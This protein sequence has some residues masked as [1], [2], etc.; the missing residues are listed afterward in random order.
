MWRV[1]MRGMPYLDSGDGV[2]YVDAMPERTM[3]TCG[4]GA[5]PSESGRMFPRGGG[6]WLLCATVIYWAVARFGMALFSLAPE[7]ITPLWLASGVGLVMCLE[8]GLRAVPY[9]VLA[10]AVANFPGLSVSGGDSPLLYAALTGT[11]DGL[12][13]GMLALL[14]GRVLKGGVGSVL[15]LLRGVVLVCLPAT[16]VG[17]VA[18]TVCLFIGGYVPR[19]AVCQMSVSLMAGD[20]LGVLL[21]FPLWRAWRVLPPPSREEVYWMAGVLCLCLLSIWG[22]FW[23]EGAAVHMLMPLLVLLSCNARINGV[24]VVLFCTVVAVFVATAHTAGPF[25]MPTQGETVML[26]VSFAASTTLTTLGLSL[27]R[28]L[29]TQAGARASMWEQRAGVDPLTGLC[30]RARF[31]EVLLAELQRLQRQDSSLSLMMFDADHFKPYNDMYGHVAG[32]ECLRS[33]ARVL[34]GVAHRAADVVARYGGEEFVC[35]LPG[36]DSDGAYA[37]AEKVRRGV[38]ALAIPHVGSPVA[39]V[40]TVSAGVVTVH[41]CDG[42]SPEEVVAQVDRALYQA[43]GAGR[44]RVMVARV[45]PK[46]VQH[47]NGC[48]LSGVQR[49]VWNEDYTCGEPRIDASHR[50]LL[51]QADAVIASLVDADGFEDRRACVMRLVEAVRVHFQEEEAVLSA[52]EYPEA[53]QH[54]VIHEALLRRGVS[55][56]AAWEKGGMSL[57][58]VVVTL[59]HGMVMRHML[60]DDSA[61]FA[62]VQTRQGEEGSP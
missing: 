16:L 55:L 44:D 23:V 34:R 12:S 32:D 3:L 20:T 31:D 40:L 46:G 22:A 9:I 56:V 35:I 26:L 30:N 36:T 29:L 42:L 62:Y 50:A 59:V 21:V 19:D 2:L 48:A 25:H 58:D 57:D 24:M 5:P 49:L 17:G 54:S 37:L 27:Y 1:T 38:R 18:I 41:G 13:A 8:A 28:H 33:V 15:D 61:F 11:V 7:N 39:G 51:L 47:E 10:S 45:V 53:A 4:A 6:V 52:I 14:G 43:K 60:D